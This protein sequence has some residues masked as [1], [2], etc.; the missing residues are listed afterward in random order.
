MNTQIETKINLLLQQLPS[1]AVATSK[2]LHEKGIS[3]SLTTAY[4]RSGWLDRLGTG[5]VV[6]RG[7][8]VSWLGAVYALQTQLGLSVH[9]GGKTALGLLGAL[10]YIPLGTPSVELF[11]RTLE[12]LPRWFTKH[13]WS[14]R[15]KVTRSDLFDNDDSGLGLTRIEN[16]EFSIMASSNERAIMEYLY[17]LEDNYQGDEPVKLMEGMAWLRPDVVQRLLAA[18]GSVKVKRLFLYLAERENHP[19]LKKLD[20]DKVDFGKGKRQFAQGGYLYPRYQ[21]TV[22]KS[23]HRVEEQE[24]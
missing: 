10:H 7:G 20:L 4:V 1:G 8:K 6:R 2:W 15:I 24:A 16:G 12:N 23:W 9:P 22:P 18:C 21:I 11:C 13:D 17:L 5:A 14:A 3:L 19:W